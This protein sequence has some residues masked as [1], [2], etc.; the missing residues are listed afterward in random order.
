MTSPIRVLNHDLVVAGTLLKVARL[1]Q[2]WYED[3]D[4]PEDMIGAL[5]SG[6]GAGS[7]ADLFTFWQRLPDVTPR[8]DYH[9]EL[10]QIAALPVSTYEH[11]WSD[12]IKSRTRGLIRKSEKQGVVVREAEYTDEFVQGITRIFN[13]S[14]MRQGKPFWHY[15]K[16]FVT[17][18]RQFSKYLFRER[19]I[20]AYYGDEL[21]GFMMIGLAQKYA[22]TGQIISMIKHRDKATNNLLIAKAVE[23]CAGEKIPYLVYLHW[24]T[25]SL[26]EFK[27][28]C[29]FVQVSLPRYWVPL[30]PMGRLALRFDWHKGIVSKLPDAGVTRLKQFR[31]AWYRRLYALRGMRAC[32]EE[33]E[34]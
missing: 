5:A 6:P 1:E 9:L 34:P 17:V 30:T 27:R 23:I 19:L 24:G 20:G 3:V 29:G 25:G 10:E 4:E 26:A 8:Y 7:R 11:W 32:V 14:P 31:S 33:G 15:G 13:E 12:Q 28:R 22:V 21:I 16:D 18:K 2:E